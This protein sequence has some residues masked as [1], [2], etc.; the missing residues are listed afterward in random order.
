MI[1]TTNFLNSVEFGSIP[2]RTAIFCFE[3]DLKLGQKHS[4]LSLVIHDT[5]TSSTSLVSVNSTTAYSP[6]KIKRISLNGLLKN[7]CQKKNGPHPIMY[8][9]A[10]HFLTIYCH[11]VGRPYCGYLNMVLNNT[12]L[13]CLLTWLLL[14]CFQELTHFLFQESWKIMGH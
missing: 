10:Y 14:K 7:T 13:Q 12:W 1:F 6:L 2:C 9:Y 4:F 5:G 3:V 8:M 11:K